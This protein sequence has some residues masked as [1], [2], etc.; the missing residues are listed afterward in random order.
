M[1]WA[2]SFRSMS[3]PSTS[4]ECTS[5]AAIR[6]AVPWRQY[7]NSRWQTMPGVAGRVGCVLERAAI[8]VFSSTLSTSAPWGLSRYR[9][10][11]S[12]ARSKKAGSSG[13]LSQPRTRWGLRSKSARIRPTWDAEIGM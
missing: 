10:H 11:T 7:S 3:R 13:R 2:E 5:N 8:A 6:Q 9:P 1:K 12:A 4:P